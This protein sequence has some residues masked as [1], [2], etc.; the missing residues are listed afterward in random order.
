MLAVAEGENEVR[1]RV[2]VRLQGNRIREMSPGDLT[3]IENWAAEVG[4]WGNA[5]N[6]S[7]DLSSKEMGQ[8][9][10]KKLGGEVQSLGGFDEGFR[11]NPYP[12][13]P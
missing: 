1:T 2:E 6:I 12:A 9:E 4:Y 7:F 8:Q 5:I 3:L 10:G 13:F 11:R